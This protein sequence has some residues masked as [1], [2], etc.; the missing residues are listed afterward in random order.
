ML[1]G[2]RRCMLA[3]ARYLLYSACLV[4]TFS[5][6]G[7][8]QCLGAEWVRAGWVRAQQLPEPAAVPPSGPPPGHPERLMPLWPLSEQER[9]LLAQLEC[10]RLARLAAALCRG[11]PE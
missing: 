8:W 2:F 10:R 6:I 5:F 7:E 11:L 3:V 1:S 4:S 9:W